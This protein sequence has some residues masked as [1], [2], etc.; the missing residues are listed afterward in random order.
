MAQNLLVTDIVMRERERASERERERD[1]I[2]M[3]LQECVVI[4]KF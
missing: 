1:Q 2:I 3:Y 4:S